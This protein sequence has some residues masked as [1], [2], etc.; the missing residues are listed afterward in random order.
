MNSRVITVKVELITDAY[1]ILGHVRTEQRRLS[2]I[3]NLERGDSIVV[4]DALTTPVDDPEAAPVRRDI[5][6]VIKEQIAFGIPHEPPSAPE[7]R[8]KLHSFDFVEKE[9][10]QVLISVPPFAISGW[11]HLLKEVNIWRPLRGLVATF[12][13]ITEARAVHTARPDLVWAAE[14]IIVNRKRA[15]VIWPREKP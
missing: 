5:A 14:T 13:P 11:I 7:D 8:Q 6:H 3:L 4:Q 15:H 2:D 12:L 9:R 1:R 10:H